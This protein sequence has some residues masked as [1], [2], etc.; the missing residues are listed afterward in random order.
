MGYPLVYSWVSLVAQLIKNP[1]AMWETWVRSLSWEDPLEKGKA[2]LQYSGLENSMDCSPQGSSIHEDSPLEW[3]PCPS[4]GDL[5]NSGIE[6]RSPT[7]QTDSLPAEPPGKPKNTGVGGLCLVFLSL[8]PCGVR[9]P[10]TRQP[11][12][13]PLSWL[14]FPP[15][16]PWSGGGQ[17]TSP[18]Y[19]SSCLS[20]ST[21]ITE[22]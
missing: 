15:G 17:A 13:H 10:Q 4:P 1:P 5:P 19:F 14:C 8:T 12:K 20:V 6:P 2:N 3:V 18:L 16:T 22:L 21:P 9:C 7:L 11:M